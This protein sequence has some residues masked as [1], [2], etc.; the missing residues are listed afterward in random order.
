MMKIEQFCASVSC[1]VRS[2]EVEVFW[3]YK[4]SRNSVIGTP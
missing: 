2:R 1:A 3:R 4:S